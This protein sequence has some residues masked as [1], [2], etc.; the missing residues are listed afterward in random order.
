MSAPTVVAGVD[1]F[2]LPIEELLKLRESA[3]RVYTDRQCRGYL[4]GGPVCLLEKGHEG[5]HTG[6]A[7]G[8]PDGHNPQQDVRITVTWEAAPEDAV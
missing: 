2:A 5:L 8:W 7:W 4:R 6:T 3:S 1:L